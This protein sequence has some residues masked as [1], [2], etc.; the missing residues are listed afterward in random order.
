MRRFG[1]LIALA[2]LNGACAAPELQLTSRF[3]PGEVR[4]YRVLADAE[5]TISIADA[6]STERTRLEAT[7]RVTVEQVTEGVT[8][9]GMTITPVHLTRDGR[10]IETP[11]EQEVRIEVGSDGQ[12][13]RV[14]SVE[15]TG[16]LEAAEIEDLVPLIGPPLPAGRV[17]LADRWRRA[18][19][20]PAGT[21][22]G[23][24]DARLAGLRVIDGYDCGIVA[25]STRRPIVQE[26]EI[27][28]N[29]F[30]LEGIEYA[31]GEIAFA[32]REGMPVTVRS[33]GEARLAISGAA[34]EGGGVVIRSN[35]VVTLLRRT[36]VG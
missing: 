27:A 4:L 9:L 2:L 17:H 30:R 1:I 31:A 3:S 18:L 35:S 12:I 33:N 10:R 13:D 23:T 29:L 20:G 28:G 14:T 5:V 6:T 15:G 36:G 11:S 22:A 34:A 8:T 25:L 16:E 24:Q 7:T 32:F 26:R 21:P 19:P